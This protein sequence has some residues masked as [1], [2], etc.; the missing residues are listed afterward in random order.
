MT[1]DRRGLTLSIGTH[2]EE[3]LADRILDP[4][5]S[6]GPALP[7][8]WAAD[9]PRPWEGTT[10]FGSSVLEG[11][12]RVRGAAWSARRR[13]AA[14]LHV[15][16]GWGPQRDDAATWYAVDTEPTRILAE[17]RRPT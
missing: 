11:G 13:T 15:A 5:R 16:V 8:E 7:R 4:R 1:F 6:W 10:E 17:A 9:L 2:D 12:V 3:A 14:D